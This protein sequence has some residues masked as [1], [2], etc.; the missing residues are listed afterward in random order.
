MIKRKGIIVFFFCIV[1]IV[2]VSVPD[3]TEAQLD[4]GKRADR[5]RS[6]HK[7]IRSQGWQ[8]PKA[9]HRSRDKKFTELIDGVTINSRTLTPVISIVDYEDFFV[10]SNSEISIIPG[11]RRIVAMSE[12]SAKGKVFAYAIRYTPYLGE[13]Q[14]VAGVLETIF[15]D[16]DGDG[17]FEGRIHSIDMPALPEWVKKLE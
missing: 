3:Q 7:T 15:M 14:S 11:K 6:T 1:A 17:L 10:F 5:T 12:Y 2:L 4:T 16:S 9:S 13:G 8:I